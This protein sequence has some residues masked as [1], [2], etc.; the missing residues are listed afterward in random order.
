VKSETFI[1][2]SKY[3]STNFQ[4]VVADNKE[5]ITVELLSFLKLCPVGEVTICKIQNQLHVV[6][7]VVS[8]DHL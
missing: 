3:E 5:Q 1:A 8:L 7:S 6:T 4:M 2:T